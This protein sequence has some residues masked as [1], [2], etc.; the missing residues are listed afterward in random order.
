MRFSLCN[1]VI[2]GMD[3]ARQCV[4]ARA[5]GYEGLEVAPFTLGDDPHLIGTE[6]RR[7]IRRAAEEAG[8]VVSGLH[9]LLVKPQGL[10]ITSADPSV[11]ARTFD[12]LRR[13]IGLCAD[14]GGSV[15]VHGSPAQRRLPEGAD[16][17]EARKRA[18]D[19]LAAAATEAAQ[20]Q[21]TYCLEPLAA[22][23]ANFVN[24]LA[25]AAEIVRAIDLPAFRTMIDCSAAAQSES[26]TLAEVIER[27]LPSGLVA[28]VQVNDVN[29]RGPGQGRLRFRPLLEA[30]DRCGYAGWVAVEPFDYVPDGPAA[31]ARAIGY[32]QGVTERA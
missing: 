8:I 26:G 32:L 28:H 21:V 1:E 16:A 13:L 9:W 2:A 20:A 25:E 5:L 6:R 7:E 23:A 14:L 22:P 19:L 12:V 27:W 30:L 24:T 10:S 31:A 17:V 18:I 3:W 15:L 4:F 11:R 29:S